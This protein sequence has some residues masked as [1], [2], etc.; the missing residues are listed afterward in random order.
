LAEAVVRGF[1][2]RAGNLTAAELGEIDVVVIVEIIAHTEMV[3]KRTSRVVVA[4]LNHPEF[5]KV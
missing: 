5:D 1:R 2:R 4:G 3:R